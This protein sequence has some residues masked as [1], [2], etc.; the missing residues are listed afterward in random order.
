MRDAPIAPR[1]DLALSL[2]TCARVAPDQ[3][4]TSEVGCFVQLAL[5]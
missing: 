2:D 5:H 3:G 4:R 1:R